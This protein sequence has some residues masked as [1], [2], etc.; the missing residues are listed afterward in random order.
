[1]SSV[2]IV[3][4]CALRGRLSRRRCFGLFNGLIG[5]IGRRLQK[6]LR[7]DEAGRILEETERWRKTRRQDWTYD[8]YERR[9]VEVE[10]DFARTVLQVKECQSKMPDS[11][12]PAHDLLREQSRLIAEPQELLV[13]ALR[14]AAM[15]IQTRFQSTLDGV[16]SGQ[17]AYNP[18]SEQVEYAAGC[19]PDDPS[20]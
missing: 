15:P 8:R 2:P 5:F 12:G 3:V 1:M 10:T 6:Y 7:G 9:V 17:M 20:A 19:H 4:A 11:G 18:E 13:K 14:V 16:L